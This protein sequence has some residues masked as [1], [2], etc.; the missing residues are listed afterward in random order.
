MR[1]FALLVT[2]TSAGL[3]SPAAAAVAPVEFGAALPAPR[4]A[5][6]RGGFTLPGGLDVAIA[7]T[8]D[9]KVDGALVL[10]SQL[11]IDHGPARLTVLAGQDASRLQQVDPSTG[12]S[13]AAGTVRLSGAGSGAQR[14]T[15]S[16]RD[17]DVTHLLGNAIG[18]TIANR[19]DNRSFD[20]STT[21]DVSLANATP[22]LLGSALPQAT[23]LASDVAARLA[24]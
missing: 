21:V 17:Y 7:I 12:V 13:T 10:R 15:L 6:M 16:G 3:G 23:N 11:V 9:T 19:G 1:L 14:L 4:L 5:A 18:S 8:T 20:V 22:A 2:A 24:R